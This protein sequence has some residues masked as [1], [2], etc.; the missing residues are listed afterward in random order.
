MCA[1]VQF[2]KFVAKAFIL[3]TP[4]LRAT[5]LERGILFCYF[6]LLLIKIKIQRYADYNKYQSKHCIADV[7]PDAESH[8]EHTEEHKECRKYR[9]A[10]CLVGTLSVRHFLSKDKHSVC[11]KPVEYP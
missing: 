4:S 5:P 11:P 3:H 8:E 1:F 9:I 7:I 10:E 6:L 2:E